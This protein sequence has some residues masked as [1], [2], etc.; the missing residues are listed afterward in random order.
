MAA[1]FQ[2]SLDQ[3]MAPLLERT[4]R[5]VARLKKLATLPRSEANDRA[6]AAEQREITLAAELSQAMG[7]VAGQMQRVITHN[8]AKCHELGA[9]I[10]HHAAEARQWEARFYQAVS[11]LPELPE[12]NWPPVAATALRAMYRINL[13]TA[14]PAA[15]QQLF[16]PARH[17]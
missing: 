13:R 11:C 6:M 2:S 3:A 12:E 14:D 16:A 1:P 8:T 4:A 15:F 9:A 7:R 5:R 17:V 10:T